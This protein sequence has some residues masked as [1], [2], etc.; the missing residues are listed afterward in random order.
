MWSWPGTPLQ[1]IHVDFA[2]PVEGHMF[3]VVVDAH[4]KWPE[5]KRM[6]FYFK[7]QKNTGSQDLVKLPWV[8]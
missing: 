5:V 8:T 2:G 4:Y 6:D 7:L 1:R 3:V